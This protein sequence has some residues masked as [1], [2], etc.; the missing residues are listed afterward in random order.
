MSTIEKAVPA[1]RD[2]L[3]T[4][5]TRA[6]QSA[7]KAAISKTVLSKVPAFRRALRAELSALRDNGMFTRYRLRTSYRSSNMQM[8]I[9]IVIEYGNFESEVIYQAVAVYRQVT[10]KVHAACLR[11]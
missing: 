6:V 4:G 9:N 5:L 2:K 11:H 1:K 10:G 3:P 7:V 8:D